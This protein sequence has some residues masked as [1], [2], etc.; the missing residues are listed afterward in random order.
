MDKEILTALQDSEFAEKILDCISAEEV[1][2]YFDEIGINITDEEADNILCSVYGVEA[3]AAF[4]NDY[5]LALV[6][7]GKSD[8]AKNNGRNVDED[9]VK[10]IMGSVGA[11]KF[12]EKVEKNRKNDKLM[13]LR[14]GAPKIK[15]I[16]E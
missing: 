13:V 6:A 2:G 14:Y 12:A 7:G 4:V 5:D 15:Q 10:A 9:V 3:E 8:N 1:Q 16:E 11:K